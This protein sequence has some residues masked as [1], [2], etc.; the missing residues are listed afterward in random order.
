VQPLPH[1]GSTTDYRKSSP[2]LSSVGSP[3]PSLEH[4]SLNPSTGVG[5]VS[6]AGPASLDIA[7][8]EV[9]AASH[10]SPVASPRFSP[11]IG[12]A[13][14][15]GSISLFDVMM[16][17][18][19]LGAANSRTDLSDLSND[20]TKAL[21]IPTPPRFSDFNCSQDAPRTPPSS[22]RSFTPPPFDQPP[23]DLYD[24]FQDLLSTMQS[25]VGSMEDQYIH[26][27]FN[28]F[29]STS[30]NPWT[31]YEPPSVVTNTLPILPYPFSFTT[32]NPLTF[33]PADTNND[34]PSRVQSKTR[35]IVKPTN[36]LWSPSTLDARYDMNFDGGP[37]EMREQ[38]VESES[39]DDGLQ[40]YFSNIP[41]EHVT[42]A[43]SRQARRKQEAR[44]TCPFE[45][46]NSSFTRKHNLDSE[47]SIRFD[48]MGL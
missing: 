9:D 32:D 14:L 24:G 28:P 44:F 5:V 34:S 26:D 31:V 11:S 39:V 4:D 41:K 33:S 1:L 23:M 15:S 35:S 38:P 48:V 45:G 27:Q 20:T 37:L 12:S 2:Q 17:R 25:T 16:G 3:S 47:C 19:R 36:R 29:P 18:S 43:K 22:M 7:A 8:V 6:S 13:S 10:L 42:S 30:D 40:K 21:R 46:C